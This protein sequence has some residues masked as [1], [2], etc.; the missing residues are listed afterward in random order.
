MLVLSI[1][2]EIKIF[3]YFFSFK[4]SYAL[5]AV[6]SDD[7]FSNSSKVF[8][9]EY[10]NECNGWFKTKSV[11]SVKHPVHDMMFA[12]SMGRSFHL[13]AIATNNIRILMFKPLT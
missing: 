7:K 8:I 10:D 12:P 2:I 1:S 5:L 3:F 13:L 6:G 9:C 4:S 11:A